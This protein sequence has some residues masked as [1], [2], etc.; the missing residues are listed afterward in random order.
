MTSIDDKTLVSAK[1]FKEI[2]YNSS[3]ICS[4]ASMFN[5]GHSLINEEFR[6]K[7]GK[8][9]NSSNRTVFGTKEKPS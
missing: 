5:L 6:V 2:R 7:I 4:I 1:T 8:Y 9:R 3:S